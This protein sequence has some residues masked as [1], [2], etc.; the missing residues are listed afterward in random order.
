[1]HP[2]LA[3]LLITAAVFIFGFDGDL[4]FKEIEK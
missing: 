1:V 2:P 4:D 3:E